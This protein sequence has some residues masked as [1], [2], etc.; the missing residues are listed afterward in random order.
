M[1]RPALVIVLVIVIASACTSSPPDPLQGLQLEP[2]FSD[3]FGRA[4]LGPNWKSQGGDWRIEAGA[5]HSTRADNRNLVLT[6]VTLPD[7]AAIELTLWSESDAVDI[8]FNAWGDGLMHDHGDGYSFILGGWHN[9]FSVIS[10]LH[11]HDK[12]RVEDRSG[13]WESFHRYAVKVVRQGARITWYLDGKKFLERV[14][15]EPLRA[16][17]GHNRLSL[18]NW[19]SAVFFDDLKIHRISGGK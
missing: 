13:G 11:E 8:K 10:K 19:R 6:S 9:R 1:F 5:A 4:E 3:D 18:A 7:D 17:S 16:A 14:D 2:V 15:P 12:A